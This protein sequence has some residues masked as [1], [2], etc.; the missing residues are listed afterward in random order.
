ML[1][2]K[3]LPISSSTKVSAEI[4]NTG[5]KFNIQLSWVNEMR[6]RVYEHLFFETCVQE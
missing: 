2:R 5:I 4:F 3:L 1:C 6:S